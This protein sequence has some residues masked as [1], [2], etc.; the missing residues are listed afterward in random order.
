MIESLWNSHIN[1]A[2]SIGHTIVIEPG[3]VTGFPFLA[4]HHAELGLTAAR[5][6]VAAFL[7]LNHSMAA[8]A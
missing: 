8:I 6:M 1:Q 5:H 3:T 2:V 7:E 4:T